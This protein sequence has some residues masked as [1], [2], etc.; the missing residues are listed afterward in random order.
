MEE[1]HTDYR[2][3]ISTTKNG[4]TCQKWT[5]QTPH[6]HDKTP[7]NYPDSGLGDHNHCRNPT[8]DAG[9]AWCFTTDPDVKW[10]W[11]YVP[12]C[13]LVDGKYT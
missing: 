1:N 6:A 4:H 10:D 2:G 11:C 7:E 3:T 13:S 5:E 12:S 8:K 9:G